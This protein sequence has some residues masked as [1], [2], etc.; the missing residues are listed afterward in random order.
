M[1]EMGQLSGA[2]VATFKV[3]AIRGN[4]NWETYLMKQ[5]LKVLASLCEGQWLTHFC[6]Q[7]LAQCL[8]QHTVF[9][10]ICFMNEWCNR[11]WELK[12]KREMVQTLP[13]G[14]TSMCKHMKVVLQLM[15]FSKMSL[16][17]Q[18]FRVLSLEFIV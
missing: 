6:F 9:R 2:L 16:C 8:K 11:W 13:F 10:N 7:Y 12:A 17:R 1:N 5:T 18:W 3:M 14:W 4:G 15:I